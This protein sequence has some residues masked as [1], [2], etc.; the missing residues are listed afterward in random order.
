LGGVWGV[1]GA[2]GVVVVWGWVGVC[3]GG[4]YGGGV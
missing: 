4:G 1:G 2:G 3:E